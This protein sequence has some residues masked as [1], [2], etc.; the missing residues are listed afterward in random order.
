M[1]TFL[2]LF[3]V[4][5]CSYIA[6][7]HTSICPNNS[8]VPDHRINLM[9]FKT[10]IIFLKLFPSKLISRTEKMFFQN[11][12]RLVYCFVNWK[13][14]APLF[15]LN[16]GETTALRIQNWRDPFYV[17]YH[18]L[19]TQH[20]GTIITKSEDINFEF[21]FFRKFFRIVFFYSGCHFLATL[22]P[23]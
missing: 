19:D 7:R 17:F 15:R 6:N 2:L 10:I 20:T 3:F 11:L 12:R 1:T 4:F 14:I 8:I 18:H 16:P 22:L 21:R 9:E 13:A 23:Y 5:V